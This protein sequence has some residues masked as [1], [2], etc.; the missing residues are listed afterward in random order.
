M[1]HF[2]PRVR[3]GKQLATLGYRDCARWLVGRHAGAQ[4]R[5]A[6]RCT[7]LQ[8]IKFL[9]RNINYLKAFRQLEQMRA[10]LVRANMELGKLDYGRAVY[11]QRV[12]EFD[13]AVIDS[14]KAKWYVTKAMETRSREDWKKAFRTIRQCQELG[15]Q[16]LDVLHSGAP[17][18]IVYEKAAFASDGT[19]IAF[20]DGVPLVPEINPIVILKGSDFDMGYQYAQQIIQVFGP[21]ILKRKAGRHFSEEEC[22]TIRQWEE[23]IQRHAPEIPGFCKGW[24][25]GATAAGVRMSYDDVLV[26]WTGDLPP[27]TNYLGLGEGLPRLAPPL[28]SGVAAWGR[29]TVD[30]RL[31][32][33][34]SG[35]HDPAYAVTIVAFPETGNNFITSLFSA[36]GD[37]PTVGPV[38]M[39]GHPGMNNKGLAYVHHGGE[40]RM[41]EPR[42][43]WG[44][45]IRRGALTLHILR[46]A[47]NAREAL[48]MELSCPV[49]D[50]GHAMGSVGGF[51]ADST[52]AYVL[53]S[54]KEPLIV[55]QAG[56]MGETDFLYANNSALH[57]DSGQAGWMQ[58]KKENWSW[59][60]HGGWHPAK[61]VVPELFSRPRKDNGVDR[62]N[63]LMS[64]M[65]HNS[66][67]RNLYAYNMMNRAV[68]HID[69]E[70][71]KMIYRQSG[72][73]P[74]GSW[75]EITA[76]YKATGRWGE[77]SI[78][79]AGNALVA[80]M[81]PD[82]GDEGMYALCVGTAARG[83]TPN[84][85][86]PAG[87]PIHAE[88]NAFWELRLASNPAGV[89]VYAGRKAREYIA[90]ANSAMASLD[91]SDAAYEPLRELVDL[92]HS[93]FENGQG[94]E[95]AANNATGNESIYNRARATRIYA[96]AQIR[97]LQVYQA[98]VSPP[99]KP[100]DVGLEHF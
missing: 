66:Y 63:S 52:Y 44:Y 31:V 65:Y 86:N 21:W 61:L 34:S 5:I 79:H 82:D 80:V 32:T 47:D 88:T 36:T 25:A 10:T 100:E 15:Q 9:I 40:L 18:S 41:I 46:F 20:A 74:P 59:D 26:L 12:R 42:A 87:G 81:K 67:G 14:S 62:I 53:E 90:R 27:A 3:P 28:C 96:R 2:G 23:Q 45:G 37:V 70:Y 64:H 73:V 95:H 93:E 16:L 72:T 91:L 92:A 48:D 54:R 99:N 97:A 84:A 17:D 60:S 33:G 35:D 7:I 75:K 57:P 56:M 78:G 85:P 98:F 83:L 69:L 30:G 11:T 43:L 50:V 55:R 71:M 94:Y 49:G 29:A 76:A 38:Y 13:Q 51:Y 77:F 58:T 39:M 68:G 1:L 8:S 19:E 24:A 4:D 6:R 89:A 22:H